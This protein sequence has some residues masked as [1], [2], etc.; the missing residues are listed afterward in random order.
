MRQFAFRPGVR[1]VWVWIFA[2]RGF[3][4]IR[5]DCGGLHWRCWRTFGMVMHIHN[6]TLG[7]TAVAPGWDCGR[8]GFSPSS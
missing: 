7:L 6:S 1:T 2:V 4:L 8:M 3:E 5:I